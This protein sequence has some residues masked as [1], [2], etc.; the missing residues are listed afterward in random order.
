MK[1]KHCE[2]EFNPLE[3]LQRI[4]EIKQKIKNLEE[5]L[6]QLNQE[7]SAQMNGCCDLYCWDLEGE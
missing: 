3:T 5:N 1:C 7:Y 6:E 2:Q 4:E